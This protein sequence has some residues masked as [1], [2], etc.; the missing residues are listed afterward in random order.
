M[1]Q[2]AGAAGLTRLLS[3]YAAS[4]P[5]AKLFAAPQAQQVVSTSVPV[6]SSSYCTCC[7][8]AA[9][10]DGTEWGNISHTSSA[11]FRN[12]ASY[13]HVSDMT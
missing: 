8:A 2:P 3:M 5:C 12:D 4:H 6:G 1:L 7:A 13:F 9:H 11:H 10:G